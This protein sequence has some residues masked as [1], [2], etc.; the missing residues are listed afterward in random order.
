MYVAMVCIPLVRK[1]GLGRLPE[2]KI[3]N[4]SINQSFGPW[5]DA[6]HCCCSLGQRPQP[7]MR[8]QLKLHAQV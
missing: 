2:V 6:R 7:S 1:N 3:N 4:Q 8:P 5:F